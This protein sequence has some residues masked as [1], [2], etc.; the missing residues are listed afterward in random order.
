[1]VRRVDS[2]STS[3]NRS[4]G[5]GRE[6]RVWI[7]VDHDALASNVRRLR[8]RL[9]SGARLIAV[10]KGDAYGHGLVEVARTIL[11]AG[12][13]T[14]AVANVEEGTRLRGAG[15]SVP[16]QLIGPSLPHE[17]PDLLQHRLI[18]ALAEES[19]AVDLDRAAQRHPGCGPLGRGPDGRFRVQVE[20][21]S[22]LRRHGID[23]GGARALVALVRRLPALELTGVYTHFAAIAPEHEDL[24]RGQAEVFAEVLRTLRADGLDA[25]VHACNT[26]SSTLVPDAWFDAMRIGGGLH[27]LGATAARLGLAPTLTLRTRVALVRKVRAGDRVGYGGTHV[28][29][30]DTTLAVLPCGY[31]DGLSRTTWT[32]REVLIQGRRVRIV[33]LVSMNQMIVDIGGLPEPVWPGDEVVLLGAQGSERVRAEEQVPPGGSSYEVTTLLSASLP[34]FH[35]HRTALER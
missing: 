32:G 15:I 5:T 6:A 22:G 16:I 25:E 1:M 18:P 11:E 27:G 30:S 4:I 28:C 20:V 12:T 17:I 29:S 10:V 2:G 9:P 34:R 33:G 26:L 35:R 31:A 24:A 21:D 13:D 7:D 23:A 14:L 3:S 8:A 19:F